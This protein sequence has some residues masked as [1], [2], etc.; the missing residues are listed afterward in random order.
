MGVKIGELSLGKNFGGLLPWGF[1]ENRPF[2]R[3]LHGLGL[4][5]WRF[6][7]LREAEKV[8]TRMLWLNPDDNQG[9]HAELSDVK[10]G[11]IW[12]E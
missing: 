6:G 2:L 3:C 8:F 11:E 12:D 10:G 5:M 9:V 4:C 1:I 7:R